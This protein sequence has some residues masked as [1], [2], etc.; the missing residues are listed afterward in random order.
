MT[1]F[2]F[3]NRLQV[4]GYK[5]SKSEKRIAEFIKE[6]P[7][8]A[9]TLSSQELAAKINTSNSTLTRFCQ[10]LGYR[11]FIEFQVLLASDLTPEKETDNISNTIKKYYS[12][13]LDAAIQLFRPED[14]D[15]FADQIRHAR[16]ILIFGIGSSGMTAS[17]L[18]LRLVQMGFA[19]SVMTDSFLMLVQSG[20]FSSRD[21]I[22]AVSNSGE[23]KSVINAC[24]I[25]KS[26]GAH[27]CAITQKH[28]SSLSK[29]ADTVLFSGDITIN[30]DVSFINSQLPILFLIDILSYHLLSDSQCR[31]NRDKTQQSLS[32][33]YYQ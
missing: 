19:S 12:N 17:E 6:N 20:F 24:Q 15:L 21:L 7:S 30:H 33:Q 26:T 14:I 2:C 9:V 1:D 29:I 32:D 22:I 31:D 4:Y 27:I 11:N 13:T 18:N 10:K 16:K 5:F 23:T 3:Q 28:E 25:A 8:I